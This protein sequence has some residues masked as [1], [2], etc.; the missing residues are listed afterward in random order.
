MK[1][2]R[3]RC[4]A[5]WRVD[6]WLAVTVSPFVLHRSTEEEVHGKM[7]FRE[8][9]RGWG[10]LGQRRRRGE[11]EKKMGWGDST[12][13]GQKTLFPSRDGN[14]GVGSRTETIRYNLLF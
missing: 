12:W 3:R 9:G 7:D 4:S 8:W 13:A 10:E 2:K 11:K 5:V 6:L 1:M 14:G